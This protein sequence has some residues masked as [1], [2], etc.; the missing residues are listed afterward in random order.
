MLDVEVDILTLANES[1]T[2][3]AHLQLSS[4]YYYQRISEGFPR[5]YPC[6]RNGSHDGSAIELLGCDVTTA[7][8]IFP[9]HHHQVPQ[10]VS[11]SRPSC[12]QT[13]Y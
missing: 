7:H 12:P 10:L 13:T 3:I 1:G 4:S 5:I 6:G 8:A 2:C 11:G 9:F